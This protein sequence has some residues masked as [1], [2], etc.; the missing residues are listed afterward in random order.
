MSEYG[1]NEKQ[2]LNLLAQCNQGHVFERELVRSLEIRVHSPNDRN[3]H[4]WT[5]TILER[6]S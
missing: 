1:E 4:K 5:T 6:N 3:H 2:S